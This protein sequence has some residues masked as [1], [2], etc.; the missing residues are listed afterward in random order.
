VA[1]LQTSFAAAG[2]YSVIAN[3]SGDANNAQSA[4]GTVMITIIAPDFTI[5]AN[6][7]NLTIQA[8]QSGTV[9]LTLTPAGGYTGTV[10]LSCTGLPSEASCT[11]SPSALTPSGNSAVTG[12]LTISTTAASSASLGNHQ[13]A[14]IPWIPTGTLALAGLVGLAIS[15]ARNRRWN[16][17]LRVMSMLLILTAGWI[18]LQGCGGGG[19]SGTKN[20]GTPPGTYAI[21]VTAGGSNSEAQHSVA[22]NVTVQ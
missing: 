7:Q 1:M 15:P 11:F 13:P 16:S 9:T 4:S 6:P 3:Y 19:N 8:G 17:R 22:L 21:N 14:N 5:A 18:S 12:Q 2:S 20:A 10:N